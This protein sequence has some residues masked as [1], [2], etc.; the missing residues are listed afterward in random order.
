MRDQWHLNWTEELQV[1]ADAK[2]KKAF[3]DQLYVVYGPQSRG[4]SPLFDLAGDTFIKDPNPSV[5]NSTVN[6]L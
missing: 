6:N 5:F 3:Y 1:A 4:S 2:D